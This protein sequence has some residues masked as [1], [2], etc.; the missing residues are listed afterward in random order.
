MNDIE[1]LQAISDLIEPVKDDINGIK[2]H[3]VYITRE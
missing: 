1:L 3:L 2:T